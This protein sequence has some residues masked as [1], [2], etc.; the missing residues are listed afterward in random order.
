MVFM[1]RRRAGK[2]DDFIRVL[3][4]GEADAAL[5]ASIFH[6]GTHSIAEAKEYLAA[7][8]IPVRPSESTAGAAGT[9]ADGRALPARDR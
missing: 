7:R 5:A 6:Y 2:P 4:D 8:G 3:T 9:V 1:H